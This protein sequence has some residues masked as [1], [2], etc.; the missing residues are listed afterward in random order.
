MAKKKPK[1]DGP[2][3]TTPEGTEREALGLPREGGTEIVGMRMSDLYFKRPVCRSWRAGALP[4]SV[5]T[6]A[7][8]E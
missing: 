8:R 7:A 6:R 5:V 4:H 2:T 3:Q 1:R